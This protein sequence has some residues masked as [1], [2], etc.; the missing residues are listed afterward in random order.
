MINYIEEIYEKRDKSSK[1]FCLTHVD[2]IYEIKCKINRVIFHQLKLIIEDE[3]VR[4]LPPNL[5]GLQLIDRATNLS[6]SCIKLIENTNFIE[7]LILTRSIIEL[8]TT[9]IAICKDEKMFA[10]FL[11]NKKF[12]STKTISFA[13]EYIPNISRVWGELSN[14]IIHINSPVHGTK[15]Y[16]NE[17]NGYVM[18]SYRQTS[19]E[20]GIEEN[21]IKPIFDHSELMIYIIQC[22]IEV[23]FFHK[24]KYNGID[25]LVSSDKKNILLG[26]NGLSGYERLYNKI[27]NDC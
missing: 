17:D 3:N 19:I 20:A 25:C 1:E 11:V 10:N 8:C 14:Y 9:A 5:D 2:R 4:K 26:D 13:N 23:I 7:A 16:T 18:T 6:I 22:T 24:A 12:E 27:Y 21:L 15:K